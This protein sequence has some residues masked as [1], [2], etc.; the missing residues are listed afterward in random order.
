MEC[1][2]LEEFNRI[3]KRIED[4]EYW[5]KFGESNK[6][7]MIDAQRDEQYHNDQCEIASL[8]ERKNYW[9]MRYQEAREDLVATQ[10]FLI[11][12]NPCTSCEKVSRLQQDVQ[13]LRV[14]LAGYKAALGK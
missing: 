8:K 14:E 10:K 9:L 4:C 13:A 2:L 6:R 5:Q 1:P 11:A 12:N 3:K 7:E